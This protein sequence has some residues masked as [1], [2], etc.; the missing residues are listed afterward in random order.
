MLS[1]PQAWL[2]GLLAGEEHVEVT[3][4]WLL[5]MSYH[6]YTCKRL[7]IT[8]TKNACHFLDVVGEIFVSFCASRM[9]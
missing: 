9:C 4:I 2:T 6:H 7:T 3:I 8:C 5:V 1:W